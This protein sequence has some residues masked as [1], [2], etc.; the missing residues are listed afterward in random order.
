MSELTA[1][2][3]SYSAARLA[4]DYSMSVVK[5]SWIHKSSPRRKWPV[6]CR[7]YSRQAKS[8]PHCAR[9]SLST[10]THKR[11]AA[12]RGGFLRVDRFF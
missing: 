1:L 6:C 11:A 10:F 7:Q 4:T 3:T 2:S 5:K 8:P 9:G 12:L